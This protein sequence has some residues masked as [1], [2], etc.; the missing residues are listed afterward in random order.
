MHKLRGPHPHR[1]RLLTT[2]RNQFPHLEY[3]VIDRYTKAYNCIAFTI[4]VKDRWVWNEI[5]LNKDGTSSYLEFIRFYKKHGYTPTFEDDKATVCIY[6]EINAIGDI[7][8]KHGSRKI[9]GMWYSKMGSGALLRHKDLDVFRESSY[10]TPLL[11]FK[12]GD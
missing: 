2:Y 4:G 12:E 3:E 9:E 8:V 10:G 11:K 5:D 6:G 1:P 7:T